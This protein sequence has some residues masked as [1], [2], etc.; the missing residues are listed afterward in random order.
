VDYKPPDG[1]LFLGV[2]FSVLIV[3][4]KQDQHALIDRGHY[5]ARDG[6]GRFLDSL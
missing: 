2:G 4:S 6:H 5:F 3:H 1:G